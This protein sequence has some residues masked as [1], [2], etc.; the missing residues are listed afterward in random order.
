MTDTSKAAHPSLASVLLG[1][2]C[3]SLRLLT[4]V[5]SSLHVSNIRQ[6]GLL[7]SVIRLTL[8]SIWWR[9]TSDATSFSSCRH[10]Y[11]RD[12]D[13][14]LYRA[15][16][17]LEV[18]HSKIDPLFEYTDGPVHAQCLSHLRFEYC[19]LSS[20]WWQASKW[21]PPHSLRYF[22]LIRYGRPLLSIDVSSYAQFT[23]QWT[24]NSNCLDIA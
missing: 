11:H 10:E 5:H 12:H 9:V 17:T 22:R 4:I 6:L 7:P 16:H 19:S 15:L 3:D 21:K 1:F 24:L 13:V 18:L 23:A 8:I 14:P 2:A 20:K